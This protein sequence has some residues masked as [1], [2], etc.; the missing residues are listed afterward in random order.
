LELPAVSREVAGDDLALIDALE[1]VAGRLDGEIRQGARSDPRVKVLTQLRGVG[2]F[3]ALVIL[4]GIGGISQFGRR[5]NW[6][7]G[8]G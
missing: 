6:R 3:T 1:A 2:P 4:A 5:A 7:R 8:P